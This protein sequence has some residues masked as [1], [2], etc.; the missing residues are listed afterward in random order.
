[1]PRVRLTAHLFMQISIVECDVEINEI[2]LRR[3]FKVRNNTD[4]FNF[5]VELS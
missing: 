1:M 3:I 5:N 4:N 2:N